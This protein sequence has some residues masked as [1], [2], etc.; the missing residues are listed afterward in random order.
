M[1]RS[2]RY[3]AET[4]QQA[5]ALEAQPELAF[6][7]DFLRWM[8]SDASGALLLRTQ[9][10][11]ATAAIPSLRIDWLDTFSY[12]NEMPVCMYAGAT[13]NA[14][15]SLNGWLLHDHDALG[16][17]SVFAVKQDV[18]LLNDHIPAYTIEKPL[19][20]IVARRS[21]RAD[22][23]D[24]FLPHLSSEYFRQPAVR[25][26]EKINFAIPQE[27]WF[28]NLSTRGNTGSAS[29]YVMLDELARSGRV[30]RGQRILCFVPE[31]GR[32]ST[33]FIHLTAV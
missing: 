17:E 20:Q 29:I 14:D 9:P 16:R 10:G 7:K 28:T 6:E 23:I 24:W 11:P 12:A 21:L 13:R 26:L 30:R 4:R 15:G 8:L 32:F 5:D 1:M 3:A 31:S 19:A 33:A 22:G 2:T 27:R 25:S 18:R